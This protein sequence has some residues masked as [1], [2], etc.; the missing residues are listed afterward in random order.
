MKL[1][2]RRKL[3]AI[4]LLVNAVLISAVYY[5][6]Q[7]AFEKSFKEY[8]QNSSRAKLTALLPTIRENFDK[9]GQDWMTRR[10]PHW[11]RLVGEYHGRSQAEIDEMVKRPSRRGPPRHHRPESS[12]PNTDAKPPERRAGREERPPRHMRGAQSRLVFKS[13]TGELL[14][15]RKDSKNTTLWVEVYQSDDNT[16]QLLGFIGLENGLEISNSLDSL[17]AS[18]QQHWFLGIAV[19]AMLVSSL[20]AIPF[21]RFLVAPVLSLRAA[22][23]KIAAGN[24]EPPFKSFSKDELGLLAKDLNTL[25]ITLAD[26]LQSRQ[27][28]IA[29]ISHELRT[30]IAVFK[31]ELEGM[32]DGIIES[33]EA[34]LHSLYD[35]IN[36][37]TKLVDDL[38]QLSMSD[39]GSLSYH[40]QECDITEIIGHT[41]DSHLATLKS[42]HFEWTIEGQPGT[43]LYCDEARL[44]QLFGNFMQNTL[45]YTDSS[46]TLPGKIRVLITMQKDQVLIR[47]Q[48]SSPSVE[49]ELL[50]KLFD[51]LYRV[52]KARD[53]ASGGSG[54]GLAICASIVQAHSGTITATAS[55]LCGVSVDVTL[56]VTK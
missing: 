22:A 20:L 37:L 51:R 1:T 30:P 56:P 42:K 23:K 3:L 18:R 33:D 10:S 55:E 8:L 12:S 11:T 43:M 32:I 47:W 9:Y 52:D 21:S 53:R 17:F 19:I 5:A 36:R 31:A 25:A 46:E 29:D 48:D 44:L 35:E 13:A 39:R 34:Q 4:L 49:P 16:G 45:R 38:H 6:N 24:Y 28:W 41:F 27:Q 7:L 40:M 26:N 2:L 50:P 15:G 54:L 14:K